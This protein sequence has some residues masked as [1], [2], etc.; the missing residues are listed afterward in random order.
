MTYY[1]CKRCE[2][3]TKQK[4]E[5]FRHLNRKKKC[6]RTIN[7]YKYDDNEI[8]EL[9]LIK[10][11][12]DIT[13]CELENKT[14]KEK[15]INEIN[16]IIIKD[17]HNNEIKKIYLCDN[18]NKKFTR[19]FNLD[20]HKDNCKTKK[21]FTNNYIINNTNNTNNTINNNI[22]INFKLEPFDGE[23][24]L[25]K[26]NKFTRQSILFSKIMYTNLLKLIL[27]N[28]S[29]LNVIIEKDK[30]EGIIYK[31]DIEK[32]I[33]MNLKDI[34]DNSMYKLNKH[35]NDF[36][37]ETISDNEYTIINNV[38]EDQ[39]NIIESKYEDYKNN[40]ETQEI[41]EKYITEIYDTKKDDTI[42]FYKKILLENEK[43][44]LLEG[45]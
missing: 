2:H 28:E 1:E 20:R 42:N 25:S 22:S 8:N 43:S 37:T 30:N 15:S 41:V 21:M 14:S 35:L 9:S 4:N 40:K 32:L 26:I 34:I 12:D 38:F 45:F 10:I 24:D 19:K 44:D 29:N 5:M 17:E 16:K 13:E 27:V 36:Y 3:R 33:K 31:N 18:C 23:W 11:L 39:K 6:V 7:S